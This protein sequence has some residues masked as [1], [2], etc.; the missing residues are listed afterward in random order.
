LGATN[1]ARQIEVDLGLTQPSGERIRIEKGM[2]DAAGNWSAP[3]TLTGKPFLAQATVANG[4]VRV[5]FANPPAGVLPP[6][7]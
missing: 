4:F 3:V 2:L 5:V 7:N 6:K 1:V